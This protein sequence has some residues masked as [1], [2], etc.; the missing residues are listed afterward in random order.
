MGSTP[1]KNNSTLF[2]QI[3]LQL[4]SMD[5]TGYL[6]CVLCSMDRLPDLCF[7]FCVS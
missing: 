1:E 5:W 6:L 4:C 3:L 2:P 7:A